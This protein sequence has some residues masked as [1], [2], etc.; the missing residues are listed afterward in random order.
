MTK[1]Y[2]L[3]IQRSLLEHPPYDSLS[4]KPLSIGGFSDRSDGSFSGTM[5]REALHHRLE[6]RLPSSSTAR[7]QP[8]RSGVLHGDS[9]HICTYIYTYHR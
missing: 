5:P 9:I 2:S 6:S 8:V 1:E 7:L 3:V 4:Y